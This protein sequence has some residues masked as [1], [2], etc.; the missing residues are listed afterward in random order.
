MNLRTEREMMLELALIAERQQP[1][2]IETQNLYRID[3]I[4]YQS[5]YLDIKFIY[6]HYY[7]RV[8]KLQ[9]I[10]NKYPPCYCLD[11]ELYAAGIKPIRE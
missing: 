9:D 8:I 7:H 10:E 3:N 2:F 5:A 6:T 1:D 11:N 4:I